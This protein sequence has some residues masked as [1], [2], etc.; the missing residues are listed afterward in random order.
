MENHKHNQLF[1]LIDQMRTLVPPE[2]PAP[3][4]EEVVWTVPRHFGSEARAILAE[5][6]GKLAGS[7]QRTLQ[8]LCDD[9][10]EVSF[11]E[12]SEHFTSGLF[13]T[14]NRDRKN[15]YYLGLE[16]SAKGTVGFLEFPFETATKFIAQMLKNPDAEIGKDGELSSLEE[17]I[18]LDVAGPMMDSL[19]A[20]LVQSGRKNLTKADALVSGDQMNR[21]GNLDDMCQ[22]SFK[23]NCPS[24]E[25]IF[26]LYVLDELVDPLV[27][28]A[29]VDHTPDAMKQMSERVI[30][31][32]QDVP[33]KVS[34]RLS[35]AMIGL[36]DVLTL[37]KEDVILLERKMTMPI[38][39]LVNG[40]HCFEAWPA[41][42]AGHVAVVVA[43][44]N[45]GN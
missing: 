23:A 37:Q 10:F 12:V 32:M 6:C 15:C 29:L 27:G 45:T 21:F 44:Q 22:L 24:G 31:R 9:G 35:A 1:Q 13:H 40:S 33:I 7:L 25:L 43:G 39:V 5:F 34:A 41:Q 38:D 28:I 18:L 8:N 4:C 14:L 36:Q 19:V 16:Q 20:G 26:S 42:H 3:E 2:D 30:N 17:S 11:T